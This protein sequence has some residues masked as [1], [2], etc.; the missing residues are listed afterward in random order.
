MLKFNNIAGYRSTLQK[1]IVLPYASCK[2]TEENMDALPFPIAA[3]EILWINL[4]K[5]LKVLYDNN[6]KFWRKR[7]TLE[8]GKT[9]HTHGLVELT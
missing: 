7:R 5:E 6:S 9:S 4:T 2:H 8:N 1:S 3:T